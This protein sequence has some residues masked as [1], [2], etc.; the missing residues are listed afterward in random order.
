MIF[1]KTF[2]LSVF[3]P[4]GIALLTLL[5]SCTEQPGPGEEEKGY[6]RGVFIVN[7]GAFFNSNASISWFDP[8]SL[9]MVNY[10]FLQENGRPL[11]DVA[12][13]FTRTKNRGYIVVNNSQKM[14]IVDLV[15]FQSTGV[16]DKLTYPRYFMPVDEVKGY[17]TNGNLE[18]QVLVVDLI[19]QR[20][21]DTIQVGFGPEHMIRK[22]NRVFVA[23]S[24]GWGNDSTLS[25]I[26]VAT[27]LV[28]E[29]WEVGYNPVD[30]VFDIHG[31]M[32]V[33]CKGKVVWGADWTLAIETSSQLVRIDPESGTVLE[34]IDIGYIGDYYW[35]EKLSVDPTGQYV[36][37]TESGGFYRMQVNA[38]KAPESPF[39]DKMFYGFGFDPQSRMLYGLEAQSFTGPGFLFRYDRDGIRVDS[40]EVGIGPNQ[41]V[42]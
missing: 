35:P 4:T 6:A 34:R 15:T 36:Y 42:F 7:E 23:N 16:I 1:R 31:L 41:V 14:E 38:G 26:N 37:F 2:L 11:G 8:D 21:T 5:P 19:N 18:G 33:L 17:L 39:I 22:Q 13:S 3:L 12:Q 24:G 40:L 9:K 10:L 20:I 25:V 28:E 30:L 29:T 32:W 27:D